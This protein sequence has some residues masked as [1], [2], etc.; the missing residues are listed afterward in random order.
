MPLTLKVV[1]ANPARTLY[2]RL[3]FID[4][5]TTETHY[6]M[7]AEARD[8]PAISWASM[9]PQ[10]S[11]AFES[12]EKDASNMRIDGE[13]NDLILAHQAYRQAGHR[14]LCCFCVSTVYWN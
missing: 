6:L 5:N 1:R 14:P 12:G 10:E 4:T 2:E 7:G 11:L 3:G 9:V 13:P 8:G